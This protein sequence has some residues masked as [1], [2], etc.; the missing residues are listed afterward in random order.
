MRPADVHLALGLVGFGH[1]GRRFV[2]LLE[3]RGE[4]LRDRHG[5]SCTVVG[6]ATRRHATACRT[7]GLDVERALGLVASGRSL[8]SLHD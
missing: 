6:I 1:V 5:L 3:E 2:R 4:R 7:D 8:A